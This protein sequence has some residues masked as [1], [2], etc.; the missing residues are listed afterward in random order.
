[1]EG[2]SADEILKT[3]TSIEE[4]LRRL[5]SNL[6][7]SLQKL[8]EAIVR[9]S[10]LGEI[11]IKLAVSIMDILGI[12]QE[13]RPSLDFPAAPI[14]AVESQE[15]A[16]AKVSGLLRPIVKSLLKPCGEIAKAIIASKEEINRSIGNFDTYELEILARELN[17]EPK[18]ELDSD[19]RIAYREKIRVWHRGLRVAFEKP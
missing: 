15:R 5:N 8:Q 12:P 10:S 2:S 14:E 3:L 18:R 7:E 11:H 6:S 9:I 16:E 1:M 17:K 13:E 4:S 19:E